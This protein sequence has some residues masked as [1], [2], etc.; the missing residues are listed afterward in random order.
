[1]ILSRLSTMP[2]YRIRWSWIIVATLGAVIFVLG[3]V[4]YCLHFRDIGQAKGITDLLYDTGQLFFL[5]YS[6][7]DAPPWQLDFAR[8][9]APLLAFSAIVGAFV[10]VFSVEFRRFRI[11][12]RGGH[13]IVCGLGRKGSRLVEEL[14]KAGERVVVIEPDETNSELSHCR[15]LR[16]L[17]IPGRADDDWNLERAHLRCA[18]MLIA[19][20]GDD[21]TNVETAVHAHRL[22]KNETRKP[23]Q[24]VVH[25]TDP[26]LQQLLKR[27]EI[28]ENTTDSFH[29]EIV[30][31]YEVGA[32][33]MLSRSEI[34][35][36]GTDQEVTRVCIVGLGTFG[37][38]VLR[39]ILREWTIRE[40][41]NAALE[42]VIV[43]D[44]AT[45]KQESV[46]QRYQE[47]LEDVRLHFVDRDVRAP[48]FAGTD[49]SVS[50]SGET[51]DAFFICFDDD[52]L[53][54]L[55]T[56]RVRDRFGSDQPIVVRMT[57]QVGFA[58]LLNQQPEQND[59]SNGIR[60]IG[61]LDIACMRDLFLGGDREVIARA[62]HEDYVESCRSA[63]YTIKEKPN[64]IPWN[65]LEEPV[66]ESNR[67]RADEV[68]GQ[69]RKAGL[70]LVACPDRAISLYPLPD[71]VVDEL[72]RQEHHRWR[73][74]LKA[75]GKPN[76]KSNPFDKAWRE[77]S[78]AQKEQ[79]RAINRNLPAILA[80]A[81]FE[82]VGIRET[83]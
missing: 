21:G 58:S 12:L 77:L 25:V 38:A 30:N 14:R 39:R 15:E 52:S 37:E 13:I 64:A 72:A 8:F 42:I 71:A 73:I 81:D 22:I 20:T 79:T 69:L 43:D 75:D 61:F 24:C 76:G 51:F 47:F 65:Q 27:H 60:P 55:A 4:G 78:E 48:D 40:S 35:K 63:G 32:R 34:F 23:L 50:K 74:N 53:A 19:T 26:A 3:Y 59:T 67:T 7:G 70:D 5:G 62:L 45:Q 2:K 66:R 1:M 31:L 6:G 16:A 82:I 29:L 41:E 18:K 68:R 36:D 57:E 49:L 44:Q 46:R 80:R 28:F 10:S 17:L 11:G 83:E 54:T 56:L 9:T 33:L